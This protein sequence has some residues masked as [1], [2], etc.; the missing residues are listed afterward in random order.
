MSV[1][2]ST[3]LFE[4]VN[5]QLRVEAFDVFNDVNFE[6]PAVTQSASASFGQI[7]STLD[8]RILQLGAKIVF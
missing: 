7:T 1:I 5:L 3:Q 4:K 8:P 6:P 2:K